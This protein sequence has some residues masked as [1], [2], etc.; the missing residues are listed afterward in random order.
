VHDVNVFSQF[1]VETGDPFAWFLPQ[2]FTLPLLHE[3]YPKST[4]IL[5]TRDTPQRW[6]TN[7]MHWY[8]VTNRFM[9]SF[10]LKYHKDI[11]EVT[12]A[13]KHDLTNEVLFKELEKSI[14]RAKD[15]KEHN[16]RR[17]ELAD[18]YEK[19]TNK[20][21]DFVK[22]H[23][24]HRL[25]EINVDDDG[26][27]VGKMLEQNFPGTKSDCWSFDA[28]ALDNDWKDFTLKV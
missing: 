11:D 23:P 3:S 14:A 17:D 16:R 10:N 4:W 2:H 13:P 24:S 5:N 18:V 9:N 19:H 12:I 22:M 8:S 26:A 6:A 27:N 7:V 28:E 21:R 25:V 15:V 20:V 1:D